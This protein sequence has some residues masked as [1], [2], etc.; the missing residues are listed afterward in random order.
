MQVKNIWEIGSLRCPPLEDWTM[1]MRNYKSLKGANTSLYSQRKFLY[2]LFQRHNFNIDSV[3]VQYNEVK[4]GKLYKT[5]N[6]KKSYV[7]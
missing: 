6:S 3:L 7:G 2:N 5:L 4:P 1:V